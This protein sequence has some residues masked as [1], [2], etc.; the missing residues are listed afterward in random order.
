MEI[1]FSL[2]WSSFRIFPLNFVIKI[3]AMCLCTMSKVILRLYHGNSRWK[4][5]FHQENNAKWWNFLYYWNLSFSLSF[6]VKRERIFEIFVTVEDVKV[7]CCVTYNFN[8]IVNLRK[9]FYELKRTL[10]SSFTYLNKN[11]KQRKLMISSH[12]SSGKTENKTEGNERNFYKTFT[13]PSLIYICWFFSLLFSQIIFIES[14]V[15]SKS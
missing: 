7:F 10:N 3:R 12:E 11:N 4:L 5:Y 9:S 2:Y 14:S 6:C 13:A 15:S 8:C 1:L